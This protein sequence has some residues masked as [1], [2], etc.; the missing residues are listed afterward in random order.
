M[1]KKKIFIGIG[2]FWLVVI[3]GFIGIKEYTLQTG[4]EV[5]LKTVPIDPRDLFRGDYVILSYEIS[6][7]DLN[8]LQT[9]TSEFKENEQV[10]IALNKI[11]GYGEASGIF[12]NKPT[13]G[14]FIKGKV[15]RSSTSR[16]FIEY[17]IE[18]YFVP[19]GQGLK[20]E[21]ARAGSVDVKVAIDKNGNVGIKTLLQDGEEI[22]FD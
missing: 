15:Q 8:S 20:I 9:D 2:I 17:G 13:E 6:T 5:L 4:E 21:R 16:L 22:S 7:L 18:S 1:D 19:E 11:D 10:Y 3:V 12:K 14:L